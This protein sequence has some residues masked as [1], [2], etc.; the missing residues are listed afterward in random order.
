[1][2]KFLIIALF[3][4]SHTSFAQ[5]QQGFELKWSTTEVSYD[6]KITKALTF[7]GANIEERSNY[8]PY[9]SKNIKINNSSENYSIVLNNNIYETL[10]QEELTLIDPSQITSQFDFQIQ[11]AGIRKQAY[12]QITFLPIRKNPSNG[13]IE[14]LKTFEIKLIPQGIR[15]NIKQNTKATYTNQSVLSTGKWVKISV[16]TT[17]IHKITYNQLLDMGIDNPANVRVYGT[18]GGVLSKIN[19]GLTFDDL[20]LN[21]I[22]LYKGSD[23][24]FNSGDFMLFY[25]KGPRSWKYDKE[26]DEFVHENHQYSNTSHYFLTSDKT[27]SPLITSVNNEVNPN[28]TVNNYDAYKVVD[29]DKKNLLKSGQLWF[30]QIFDITTSYTLPFYFQNLNKNEN[31]SINTHVAGRSSSDSKFI[32]SSGDKNIGE[33]N[34]PAVN[35]SSYTATYAAEKRER[36]TNFKSTN[37][38]FNIKIEYEKGSS[39]SIGWL[40][41]MRL[42]AR[43]QLK[44]EGKQLAFRDKNS[45]GIGNIANFKL[46]NANS[47]TIIWDVTTP[48]EVKQIAAELVGNTANINV[49]HSKL[50]ELLAFDLNSNF[51]SPKFVETVQNQNLHGLSSSNLIIVSHPDFLSYANQLANFHKT[52]DQLKVTLVSTESI[53]NE[54]SSGTVDVS[55][56]RNFVKMFYDKA[57]TIDEMPKY[58]LLFGDG[59]YDNKLISTDNTNKI[60]T[61]Q[62]TY[63]L[64]PT[65]SFVTD[66]FFGLLDDNEGEATGLV[67]IGIGRLPVNTTEE[68]QIVVSKILNYTKDKNLGQWETSLCFIADDEDNNIHMK[69]ANKLAMQIE[70]NYPEYRTH[71]I[72]LDNYKQE[73]SSDGDRYPDV[74]RTIEDN[75][76]KGCLIVNYTGHGNEYGLAHEKIMMFDDIDSWQNEE[77]LP[78]FMTATC[79]FSRFDQ[80]EKTSGGE[81]ILLRDN[82]GGIGLFTTTRL[83]YS[84][85]NFY[86]NQNFYN[87]VFSTDANGENLRLGAI[88][89]LTKNASG[90]SNNKRNFTLLGDPAL[91]L[92][93][94]KENIKSLKLNNVNINESTDTLKAYQK[95]TISGQIEDKNSQKLNQFNGT[96]YPTVFDKLSNKTTLGNDEDPFEYQEQSNI[97][98]SGKASINNGNFS[99]SFLVPKD[100]N[101]EYGYGKIIYYAKNN[102]NTAKGYTTNIVVGGSDINNIDDKIG[103]DIELYMNNEQFVNGGATNESPLLLALVQDSSGIN[104]LGTNSTHNIIATIDQNTDKT[105]ELNDHYQADIDSYQKGQITYQLSK[106]EEGEHQLN[107]KVWD[108]LNNPSESEIDFLVAK[109]SKLAIEHLLNYPN[110]FTTNT[111]FYFEHNQASGE[112]E[113]LIQILTVS[114]KLVKTLETSMN[115]SGFRVGPINWDGKDDFGD[116]IGRGVYFYRLKLRTEDGKTATKFQKLVILK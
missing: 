106:L 76:N 49:E 30:G 32:I 17:A 44:F 109:D 111:G 67:D 40:D 9:F 12:L 89:R 27:T 80:Y 52:E 114:G 35:T 48:S 69:Q 26:T 56:I 70:S 88:M 84:T 21:R 51:P 7:D 16:D 74:N 22:Y 58:L 65:S 112:I 45:V 37:D 78:L 99:Y 66:D 98:Y 86:L 47:N 53:Y 102:T 10:S 36:Y 50:K 34:I 79:E 85:P 33:I 105:I 19:D 5:N 4:I 6:G 83:V 46:E 11:K 54:F 115:S 71:R 13:N 87:Y 68:A 60:P 92:N 41:Y 104:T 108:N 100:I 63:S 31:I 91:K 77:R 110:P 14:K 103:P 95:I 15:Q 38:Q 72:F 23:G 75:I 2:R 82:G 25:A 20:V 24:I 101:S 57:S 28:I 64:A 59:S 43:C 113:I 55:A 96:L 97:L 61:Y 93:Y 90:S 42:N 39:S 73:T 107:L 62:S 94:A 3:I 81:R 18:G 8:L 29:L 116:S 1:M